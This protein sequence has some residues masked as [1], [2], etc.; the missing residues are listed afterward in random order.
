MDRRLFASRS[1]TA[2]VSS[3]RRLISEAPAELAPARHG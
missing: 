3:G 2:A 1:A